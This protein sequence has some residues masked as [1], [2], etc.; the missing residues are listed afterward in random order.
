[1]QDL[2]EGLR[3]RAATIDEVLSDAFVVP[4]GEQADSELAARRLAAWRSSCAGDDPESFDRRLARDGLSIAEVRARFGTIRPNP[5]RP[6]PAWLAD[7]GWIIAALSAA[8]VPVKGA[9]AQGDPC[10][11]ESLLA[12]IV[13]AAEQRLWDGLTDLGSAAMASLRRALLVELSNLV[14]PALYERFDAVRGDAPDGAFDRFVDESRAGGLRKLFEDKPVLLR[15][16]AS[17][18]R[19][20]LDSSRELILRLHADLPDIRREL[21]GG[22]APCRVTSIEGELSDPHNFGRSV[23]ILG[24]EDGSHVVYKPKD[25]RVDAAWVALVD[26]LNRTAPVDLRAAR[27]LVR[28]GYGWTEFVE[29]S[30]CVGS[31]DVAQY[32]RRA[33]AW[34]ALLHCFVSVDMHQENVIAAGAHPVPIDLEMILQGADPR[35]VDA[36]DD[37]SAQAAAMQTVMD[38]VL[39]VGLLPA[40]GK[41]AEGKLFAVGGVTSNTT[42]R[43]RLAW[44][45]VNSDAMRPHRIPSP[46]TLTN[47]PHV[48]GRYARLHDHLD[49]FISGFTEYA[50]FLSGRPPGSLVDGFAGLPVRTVIRPTRFYYLLMQRMRDHRT[51]DDGLTW[52]AQADFGARLADWERDEDPTWPLQRSERAAIVELNVPH[53]VASSDGHHIHD[54]AGTTIR[55]PGASGLERAR[56]RFAGLDDDEVAWQVEVITQNTGTLSR[57]ATDRAAVRKLP[58]NHAT[59]SGAD[60]FGAESDAAARTLAEHAVRKG[61]GAAWIG[62]DWVGDSEVSQLVVLGPELYNGACGI[63]VFLAAH[64]ASRGAQPSHELALAAIA[65]IR[66]ALHGRAPARL[67]RSLGIGGGIGVGSIVYGLAVIAEFLDDASVLADGQLAAD[68][69]TDEL[70][71]ADHQLDVLGGSAGALLALLRLRRQTGS[72]ADLARALRCGRHLLTQERVGPI[73]ERTWAARAFGGPVNGMSHGAAGYAYAL[74]RLAASTGLDEFAEAAAECLAFERTTFDREHANWSD[75]RGGRRDVWPCKWCYGAPGIGL[76]RLGTLKHAPRHADGCLD[77]VHHALEGTQRGW[78]VATDTLCCGTLGTVEFLCEAGEVLDR[79]ELRERADQ[80]FLAVVQAAR[81][82]G[83]YRWSNGTSRFNL[84]LFRGIAGVGYTALRRVDPG[85]PN[86]LNWE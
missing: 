45:A 42:P 46:P 19:Q 40:Y 78:P 36:G 70:I 32:F 66:E 7:A 23:G 49:E 47:L 84:G 24:F 52:S 85:L 63:G 48:G 79:P 5:A 35:L 76:A 67:A 38:S 73:G 17:L 56:A 27:V 81:S 11:F 20:W 44:S 71:A 12:P 9:A 77:D 86:L 29:H 4:P 37:A 22:A 65:P 1:M 75:V 83:S 16:V 39:V 18:T 41:L 33:G 6:A 54:L 64:A 14:A 3:L 34:L 80:Q 60:A 8:P 28:D 57:A 82:S 50:T 68:L 59:G 72:D 15:L 61:V 55:T 74:S 21:H 51:M 53:F 43:T 10:A 25:L 26:E 62:L 2:V 58:P 69:I 13:R 31:R 30:S